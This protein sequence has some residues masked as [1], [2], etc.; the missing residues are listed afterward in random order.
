MCLRADRCRSS[1]ALSALRVAFESLE[2][3]PDVGCV[4]IANLTIFLQCLVDDLFQLRRGVRVYSNWRHR[5][6]IQDRI[7]CRACHVTPEWKHSC[8]HLIQNRTEREQVCTPI[9]FFA[10]HLLRRHIGDGSQCTAGA[11]EVLFGI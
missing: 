7:K 9:E 11:G 3:S 6:S 1:W 5:C 8:T 4:L 2:V 10:T